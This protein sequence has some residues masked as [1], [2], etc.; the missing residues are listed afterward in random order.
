[1]GYL[2]T[3]VTY[4]WGQELSV[5]HR[6]LFPGGFNLTLTALKITALDISNDRINPN[7][8]QQIHLEKVR[9]AL[10]LVAAGPNLK[11]HNSYSEFHSSCLGHFV[12]GEQI[13]GR[14]CYK[15]VCV[16]RACDVKNVIDVTLGS[17]MG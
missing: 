16:P 6:I 7:H 9:E 15:Y 14:G 1:M 17:G 2:C 10:L 11:Y 5:Y 12:V 4:L 3:L 13:L 8:E